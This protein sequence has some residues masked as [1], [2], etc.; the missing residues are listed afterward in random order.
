M[1]ASKATLLVLLMATTVTARGDQNTTAWPPPFQPVAGVPPVLSPEQEMKT[2]ALPPGYRVELVASEPMVEDPVLIDWDSRG[3]MWVVEM[4][5]YMP[6]LRA[7][8]EREPTGR[9]SV[10]EDRNGDG[11]MDA[12][13]VFLRPPRPSARAQG[14][15]RRRAG[16]RA[17]SPL[18]CARHERRLEGRQQ[19]S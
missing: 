11:R 8:T 19:S 18:V 2:F 5:G 17:S 14:A 13:T 3:R 6:D 7:S 16:R 1:A 9:V 4:L 15:G 12:K 10:L